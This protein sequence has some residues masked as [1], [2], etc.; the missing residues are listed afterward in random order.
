MENTY[1]TYYKV[2][3]HGGFAQF[4]TFTNEDDAINA[5]RA[6][7]NDNHNIAYTTVVN[8]NNLPVW[9]SCTGAGL[10][11]VMRWFGMIPA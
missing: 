3:N 10:N 2:M 11:D 4:N 6:L 8:G 5:A 1:T 9:A 7:L